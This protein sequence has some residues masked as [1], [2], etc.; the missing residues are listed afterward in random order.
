MAKTIFRCGK[1]GRVA[2]EVYI[3]GCKKCN[4]MEFIAVFADEI[5]KKAMEIIND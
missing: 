5:R 3:S 4:N 2:K 1:C